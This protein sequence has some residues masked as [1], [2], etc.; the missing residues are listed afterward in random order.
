MAARIRIAYDAF[1]RDPKSIQLHIT[2]D[3][4]IAYNVARKMCVLTAFFALISFAVQPLFAQSSSTMNGASVPDSS[5]NKV[6]NASKDD[7][8]FEN[9]KDLNSQGDDATMFVSPAD[10]SI[11]FTS[12]R[13]GKQVLYVA[14]RVAPSDPKDRSTHWGAPEVYAELP[15]KQNISSLSIASDGVTAIV[16]ICNRPDG[17]LQSCDIYQGQIVSGKLDNLTSLTPNQFR[18]VGGAAVPQPGWA[19]ALF[20]QRSKRRTRRY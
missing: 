9:L 10:G 7:I 13:S 16:G 15:D 5:A 12:S 14:R 1:W 6:L 4:S 20:C 8:R 2:R 17:I 19:T 11:Y 18:M 3:A